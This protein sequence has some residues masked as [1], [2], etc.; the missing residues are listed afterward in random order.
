MSPF[1]F[2]SLFK[3]QWLTQFGYPI[4]LTHVQFQYIHTFNARARA[5]RV[6]R[7]KENI[8]IYK[9]TKMTVRLGR[10]GASQPPESPSIKIKYIQKFIVIV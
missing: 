10:L 3:T 7:G 2:L 5:Q 4:K 8:K 9:Y 6:E 1:T